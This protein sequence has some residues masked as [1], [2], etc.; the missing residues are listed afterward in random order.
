MQL[1]LMTPVKHSDDYYYDIVRVNIKKYRLEKG[2]TQQRL[3]DETELSLD[4][5]AEIE[6]LK[7]RKS[8]SLSHLI[9]LSYYEGNYFTGL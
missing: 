7:R 3:S 9:I 1:G 6:N 4:Y 8:F 5:I 2:Y